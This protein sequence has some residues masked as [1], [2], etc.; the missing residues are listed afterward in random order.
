MYFKPGGGGKV[1]GVITKSVLYKTTYLTQPIIPLGLLIYPPP[2]KL[3]S[4]GLA[5]MTGRTVT[6]W[7]TCT[8]DY[9]TKYMTLMGPL[10]NINKK[11]ITY[12]ILTL[13]R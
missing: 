7:N 12:N 10:C 13:K 6:G 8:D 2:L 1:E 5:P 9:K 11:Y 4:T 3:N